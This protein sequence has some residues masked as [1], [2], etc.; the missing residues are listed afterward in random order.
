MTAKMWLGQWKQWAATKSIFQVKL[1]FLWDRIISECWELLQHWRLLGGSITWVLSWSGT[2]HQSHTFPKSS[3]QVGS[4]GTT[5]PNT[6]KV[7]WRCPTHHCAGGWG[8]WAE[9]AQGSTMTVIPWTFSEHRLAL[10]TPENASHDFTW[11]KQVYPR[12]PAVA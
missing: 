8:C 7:P 1:P 11:P 10:L 5:S 6:I 3:L 2:W 12:G 4:P 9:L